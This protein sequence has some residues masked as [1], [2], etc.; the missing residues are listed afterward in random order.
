MVARVMHSWRCGA[1]VLPQQR[2]RTRSGTAPS[3][4]MQASVL[5]GAA[6][7]VIEP[8]SWVMQRKMFLT[9]E[10]PQ[11]LDKPQ[12]LNKPQALDNL[13]CPEFRSRLESHSRISVQKPGGRVTE[14]CDGA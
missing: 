10:Q 1:E 7:P 12:A 14:A 13:S 6:Y 9:I 4:L 3:L 8:G 11:A 5:Q 2:M